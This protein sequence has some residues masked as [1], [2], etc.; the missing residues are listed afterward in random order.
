MTLTYRAEYAGAL[1]RGPLPR[2]R[3]VQEWLGEHLDA[4]TA[5][6]GR[7]GLP[8][9]APLHRADDSGL[10]AP[11]LAND[12]RPRSALKLTVLP[13]GCCGMA[14]T[15]GHEAEHRA[16]S[17]RIYALSWAGHVARAGKYRQAARHR[18]FVPL[19]GGARRR[20]RAAPSHSSAAKPLAR[21]RRIGDRAGA[22]GYGKAG[23]TCGRFTY[24]THQSRKSGFHDQAS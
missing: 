23:L 5:A 13:S 22:H 2:V 11:R 1:E 3:L 10:D 6:R 16:T 4:I 18:L 8:A 9:A 14:G 24:L 7:H 15:Y 20:R 17:E 12:F 21:R 19:P